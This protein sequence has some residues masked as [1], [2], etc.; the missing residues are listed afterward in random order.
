MRR[1]SG[2]EPSCSASLALWRGNAALSTR[3]ADVHPRRTSGQAPLYICGRE[4]TAYCCCV[5]FIATSEGWRDKSPPSRHI[6]PLLLITA[7]SQ[8]CA[9][10]SL[11]YGDLRQL[12]YRLP[13]RRRHGG[14]P[15]TL[16]ASGN[17]RA[18]PSVRVRHNPRHFASRTPIRVDD[19]SGTGVFA[20]AEGKRMGKRVMKASRRRPTGADNFHFEK[21]SPKLWK[22]SACILISYVLPN[23][24]VCCHPR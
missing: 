2:R 6:I 7:H 4:R 19:G 12:T 13:H 21:P 24:I 22:R 20:S 11:V 3:C 14:R 1:K 10:G 5:M 23:W 17:L 9:V 18:F 15:A 16:T 8:F